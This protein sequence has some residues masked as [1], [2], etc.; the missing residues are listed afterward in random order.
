MRATSV[1]VSAPWAYKLPA[2]EWAQLA[3]TSRGAL[4]VYIIAPLIGA[5]VGW[6]VWRALAA[7]FPG[8]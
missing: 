3:Y 6:G 5:C 7:R 1:T 2:N 8:R 4:T